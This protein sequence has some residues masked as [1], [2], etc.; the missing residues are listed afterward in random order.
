M[1]RIY[2]K[3]NVSQRG[4]R[5]H[6][7]NL[8]RTNLSSHTA[9]FRYPNDTAAARPPEPVWNCCTI[10]IAKYYHS[11]NGSAHEIVSAGQSTLSN[12]VAKLN[13]VVEV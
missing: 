9:N 2:S 13:D 3:V 6:T 8:T 4:S 7:A 11:Q 5:N 1:S 10:D 12:H